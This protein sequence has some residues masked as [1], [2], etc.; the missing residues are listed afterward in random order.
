[1]SR[2]GEKY[3]RSSL[4]IKYAVQAK[5]RGNT[6]FKIILTHNLG[7][8]V[9]TV[10]E[11]VEL[12]MGFSKA[13]FLQMKPYLIYH[14]KLLSYPM[15]IVVLLIHGIGFM[16]NIMILLL[17]VMDSFNEF[18][19]LIN[20]GLS[21]GGILSCDCNGQSYVNGGQWMEPQGHLKRVVANRS[22]EGSIVAMLKIRKALIPCAW[23]FG[24]IHT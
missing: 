6:Q 20:L 9:R 19:F 11:W 14:L 7:D 16:Q 1:V 18:G 8:G 21:M 23:M 3:G 22:V 17:D 24:I 5:E 2:R 12:L 15:L 13:L 4:H 10:S